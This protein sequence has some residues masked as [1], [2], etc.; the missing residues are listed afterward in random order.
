MTKIKA[1]IITLTL[2]TFILQTA[3]GYN[4]REISS[5]DGLSNSA[6][7]SIYQDSDGFMWFGTVDGLNIYNGTSIEVFKP[8]EGENHLSG[9]LI[10]SIIEAEKGT[11]WISTNKGLNKLNRLENKVS[12]YSKKTNVQFITKDKENRIYTYTEGNS[13]FFYHKNRDDFQ[14]IFL[15]ELA[16]ANLLNIGVDSNN[17]FW[18]V[19][20][21]GEFRSY[22]IIDKEDG[23]VNLIPEIVHKHARSTKFCMID[24]NLSL[25]HI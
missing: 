9:N 1:K 16:Q 14:E 22:N 8:S 4:I 6:V 7:L 5:S 23:S 3:S 15:E 19:T 17:R 20:E 10:E 2:C 21:E 13:I 12:Y 25:I 24:N 18:I 11:F